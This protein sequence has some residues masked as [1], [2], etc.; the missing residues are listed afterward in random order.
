VE[1]VTEIT[2]SAAIETYVSG[3]SHKTIFHFRTPRRSRFSRSA[4]AGPAPDRDSRSDGVCTDMR[5]MIELH[6]KFGMVEVAAK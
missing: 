6:A 1:H 2:V 4:S 5:E 3:R